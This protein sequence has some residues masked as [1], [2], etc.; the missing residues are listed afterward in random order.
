MPY[1]QG[2]EWN[3]HSNNE[4]RQVEQFCSTSTLNIPSHETF[5]KI[6]YLPQQPISVDLS[7]I[8]LPRGVRHFPLCVIFEPD[9]SIKPAFAALRADKR[10]IVVLPSSLMS[11][12]QEVSEV[13]LF[14]VN[15]IPIYPN[16]LYS[17]HIDGVTI[18]IPGHNFRQ[19]RSKPGTFSVKT[20]TN[21][22]RPIHQTT[23]IS[24]V[25]SLQG[26]VN[27]V[28]EG[29]NRQMPQSN[30]RPSNSVPGYMVVKDRGRTHLVQSRAVRPAC[31]P[32]ATEERR[33]CSPGCR[34]T[35]RVSLPITN[36]EQKRGDTGQNERCEQGSGA[37][38]KGGQYI[39]TVS[40][41]GT[42]FGQQQCGARGNLLLNSDKMSHL[43]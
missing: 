36:N 12:H 21:H 29:E 11:S 31:L 37:G 30:I 1:G 26:F 42:K 8:S 7:N 19:R 24:E 35:Y 6:P 10:P 23:L 13:P 27:V 4:S 38:Q 34:Q 25:C 41:G 22:R 2:L 5:T 9:G 16:K 14:H 17:V 33:A 40:L 18:N 3:A 15:S 20:S 28:V 39:G 32:D 43:F